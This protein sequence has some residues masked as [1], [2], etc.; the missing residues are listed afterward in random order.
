MLQREAH[1]IIQPIS[2]IIRVKKKPRAPAIIA[3]TMLVAANVIHR[4]ITD[5][6]IVPKIPVKR[7]VSL[8]HM[9]FCTE[10]HLKIGDSA[11]VTARYTT[12]IPNVT[13]V[14]AG[15]MVMVAVMV[16]KAIITPIRMLAMMARIVQPSLHL[17]LNPDI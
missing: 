15:E 5:V 16:R 13:Q 3:P 4:R 2:V 8:G 10:V 14:K 12:A 11:N 9:Q 17:N 7:T 1:F 6:R